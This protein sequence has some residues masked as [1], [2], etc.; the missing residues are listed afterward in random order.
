MSTGENYT[1]EIIE[2]RNQITQMQEDFAE[3][4]NAF[5]LCSMALIIFRIAIIGYWSLGWAFAFGDSANNVVGL[6]IGH[7]QFF[8]AGLTNY[9]NRF[10]IIVPIYWAPFQTSLSAF[11]Y[12]ILTHWGW[13]PQGWMYLGIQT[14][15]IH[16]TYMV[17]SWCWFDLNVNL[18]GGRY[19]W[20]FW[21][22]IT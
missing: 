17:C 15:G 9:P 19:D 8:L 1:A 11:V 13:H 3:N 22:P 12:P 16:T 2:L 10:T 6:F 5:F 21:T 7:T 4:D 14:N 20:R 18:L